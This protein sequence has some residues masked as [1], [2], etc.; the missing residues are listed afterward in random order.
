MKFTY[1]K[2]REKDRKKERKRKIINITFECI[3]QD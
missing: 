1:S 3:P 2:N